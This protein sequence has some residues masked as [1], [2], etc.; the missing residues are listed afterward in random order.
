MYFSIS[1]YCLCTVT[2]VWS[3]AS[4]SP[5]P[6]SRA[7]RRHRSEEGEGR[8][9]G[10]GIIVL[11]SHC[12]WACPAAFLNMC[13][14]PCTSCHLLHPIMPSPG[15]SAQHHPSG[16]KC[17]AGGARPEG[18]AG[19]QKAWRKGAV[20]VFGSLGVFSWGLWCQ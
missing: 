5:N 3:L 14:S 15:H 16:W 4:S 2:R 1:S 6:Q 17:P 11:C 18:R 9:A 13:I 7:P 19:G 10:G 20:L 8:K 12:V